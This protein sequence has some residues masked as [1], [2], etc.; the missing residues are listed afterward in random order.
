MSGCGGIDLLGVAGAGRSAAK[1][2]LKQMVSGMAWAG[3]R[4]SMGCRYERVWVHVL[5]AGM[6][7]P[8]PEGQSGLG[9]EQGKEQ[10]SVG[11]RYE[12]VWAI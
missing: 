8:M 9:R 6:G 12:R 10:A 7:W 3:S 5:A 1:G 4:E 2:F 11:S